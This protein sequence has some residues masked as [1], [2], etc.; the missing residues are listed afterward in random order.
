MTIQIKADAC[1]PEFIEKRGNERKWA[2]RVMWQRG[3]RYK[4]IKERC[5]MCFQG[6]Y[7]AHP[8]TVKLIEAACK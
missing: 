8:N 2:H 7:F 5:V 3:R 6:V 4:I 1:I